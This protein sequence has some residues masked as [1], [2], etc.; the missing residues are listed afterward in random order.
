MNPIF[1]SSFE[2]LYANAIKA[3]PNT[4]KRQHVVQPLVVENLRWT[5]FLGMKTLFIKGHIRN[6]DRHYDAII[7]FKNIDY[8]KKEIKITASDGLIYN[9]GKLSLENNDV[10]LRCN[11]NDFKWRFNFYDHIDKSLYGNKRK[12]YENLGGAPANPMKLP[13]MCK[14]IMKTAQALKDAGLFND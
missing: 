7:L 6:E 14:H 4:T 9:F 8:N 5:P 3:F 11:C 2:E 1:E 13:G 10:L 12:K